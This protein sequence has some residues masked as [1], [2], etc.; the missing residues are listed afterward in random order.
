[1]SSNSIDLPSVASKY[2]GEREPT[3]GVHA[4]EDWP[5]SLFDEADTLFGRDFT[6]GR[7]PCVNAEISYL[8][9]RMETYRGLTIVT[10][11]VVPDKAFLRGLSFVVEFPMFS[12]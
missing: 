7:G 4:A 3:P 2:I 8:L 5:S 1:M 12:V 10:T 6:D 11:K 9:R